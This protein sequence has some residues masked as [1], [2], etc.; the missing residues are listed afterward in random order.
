ML[1]WSRIPER[2][3]TTVEYVSMALAWI[4]ENKFVVA[5]VT[6][7]FIAAVVIKILR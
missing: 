3:G 4:V 7:F 1:H 6:P 2:E 5:A